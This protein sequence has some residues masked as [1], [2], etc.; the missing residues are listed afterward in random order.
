MKKLLVLFLLSVPLSVMHADCD[1]FQGGFYEYVLTANEDLIIVG[2]QVDEEFVDVPIDG[3]TITIRMM[4]IRVDEIWCGEIVTIHDEGTSEWILAFP[5]SEEHIWMSS[6]QNFS[7]GF[8]FQPGP[9]VIVASY[10]GSS[11]RSNGCAPY[12]LRLLEDNSLNGSVYADESFGTPPYFKEDLKE[13]I[14]DNLQCSTATDIQDTEPM[15]LYVYPIPSQDFVTVS[16][17]SVNF[18]AN[19]LT[20]R[21][22]AGQTVLSK[23]D[24]QLN[25]Q[26]DISSFS[27]GIYFLAIRENNQTVFMDTIVKY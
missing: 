9:N 8:G 3:T 24:F 10:N 23:S 12:A 25:D 22:I 19:E 6:W 5:N 7:G 17:K 1:F 14:L 26:L 20:I 11:Y 4:K 18:N 15:D 2:E 27:P 21:N 16:G 13:R